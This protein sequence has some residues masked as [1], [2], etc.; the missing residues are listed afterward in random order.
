MRERAEPW[1]YKYTPYKPPNAMSENPFTYSVERLGSKQSALL[2][3]GWI[4]RGLWRQQCWFDI[5]VASGSIG[6]S[7]E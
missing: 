2:Q 4:G 6:Q 5:E 1:V 7:S 3:T